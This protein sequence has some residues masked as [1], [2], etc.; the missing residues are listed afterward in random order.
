MAQAPRLRLGR[1]P[2]RAWCDPPLADVD[3]ERRFTIHISE[4]IGKPVVYF[5]EL[6]KPHHGVVTAFWGNQDEE[7]GER[8]SINLVYVS[9]EEGK[10]DAYGRQIE[11]ATS[12][13]PKPAQSAHGRFFTVA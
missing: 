3:Q 12:V 8:A 5:D 6:G 9:S 1:R 7:L 4:H 10:D 2:I 11:R 13:V